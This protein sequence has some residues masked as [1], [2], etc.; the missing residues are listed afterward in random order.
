MTRA[1]ARPGATSR[2]AR[3]R[4]R[5]SGLPR[6][7]AGSRPAAPAGRLASA[8]SRPS[9]QVSSGSTA[10]CAIG[11]GE[12]A[13]PLARAVLD[14]SLAHADEQ[15]VASDAEEPRASRSARLV[16]ETG[17]YEPGLGERLGREVVRRVRRRRCGAGGSRRRVSRSARRARGR[18]SHRCELPPEGRRRVSRLH[19]GGGHGCSVRRGHQLE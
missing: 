9:S 15:H 10:A 12:D 1:R 14:A 19:G 17:P 4:R 2:G 16:A 5:S 8:S 13:E 6:C 7:A 18:R 3:R 11:T